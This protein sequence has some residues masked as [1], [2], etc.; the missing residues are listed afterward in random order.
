ML[1]KL[2]VVSVRNLTTRVSRNK[3]SGYKHG[4]FTKPKRESLENAILNFEKKKDKALK[5]STNPLTQRIEQLAP[6]FMTGIC[7]LTAVPTGY[8]IYQLLWA[9]AQEERCYRS[10]TQAMDWINISNAF[11]VDALNEF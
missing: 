7:I 10:I 2:V 4:V 5:S 1:S 9:K 11:I 3:G 8:F 6:R